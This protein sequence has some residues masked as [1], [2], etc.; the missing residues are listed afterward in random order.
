MQQNR[1]NANQ[2]N[3]G[4]GNIRTEYNER[5]PQTENPSLL[6]THRVRT[7]AERKIYQNDAEPT[8]TMSAH[9][10][11]KSQ[12]TQLYK[13]TKA[14][15][16]RLDDQAP[17]TS[18]EG[19]TT[20]TQKLGSL[21]FPPINPKNATE[22]YD[23]KEAPP[24]EVVTLEVEDITTD[25]Q[26]DEQ[27]T[28]DNH[29]TN[30]NAKTHQSSTENPIDTHTT[31]DLYRG[32]SAANKSITSTPTSNP[33]VEP[34]NT[35]STYDGSTPQPNTSRRKPNSLWDLSGALAELARRITDIVPIP[36]IGTP[37]H[38]PD[39]SKMDI[40]TISTPENPKAN[41]DQKP[42]ETVDCH[43]PQR[44]DEQAHLASRPMTSKYTEYNIQPPQKEPHDM[45]DRN[46]RAEVRTAA[47]T[48]KTIC[49]AILLGKV[50]A[51]G[52]YNV[53]GHAASI[54]ELQEQLG[55]LRDRR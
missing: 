11:R 36:G 21:N 45:D 40:G 54:E 15:Q 38:P 47:D 52:S 13:S 22:A 2:S 31:H 5:G 19:M 17:T 39:I 46:T 50:D 8:K 12:S 16:A 26:R 25:V 24:K 44:I 14:I 32:Q 7:Q 34:K 20:M 1:G 28:S 51:T 4:I 30:Q 53:D 41:N 3:T 9:T 55:N 42:C 10:Y 18:N 48:E 23:K 6:H 33:V 27:A 35:E 37:Q 43:V 49:S 29:K